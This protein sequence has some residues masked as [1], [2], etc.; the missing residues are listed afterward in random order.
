MGAVQN[1]KLLPLIWCSE[2][3]QGWK[4]E[5]LGKREHSYAQVMQEY[6]FCWN[7]SSE[8][9]FGKTSKKLAGFHWPAT[10]NA[11]YLRDGNHKIKK[12]QTAQFLSWLLFI[13]QFQWIF[14]FLKF[15]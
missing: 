3:N 4:E 2:V 14:S 8:A 6:F 15:K 9:G 7:N 1:S 12:P 13:F 5:G 10:L 11:G